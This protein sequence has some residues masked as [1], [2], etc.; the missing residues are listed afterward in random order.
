ML[1]IGL[2]KGLQLNQFWSITDFLQGL[3][4]DTICKNILYT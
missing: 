1:N 2:H 3:E 4:F